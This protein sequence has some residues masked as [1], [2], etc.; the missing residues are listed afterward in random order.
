LTK[1]MA[2]ELAP[3]GVRINAICPC[4]VETPML[5]FQAATYG[6][7]DPDGYRKR[8][9]SIYPQ[10]D[11]A[12]FVRPEEVAE[13]VFQMASPK[14]APVTGAALSIDFGTTAGN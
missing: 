4:D 8:L 7:G 11:R 1:A 13:F 2:R 10:G 9:L 5:E 12:R 14:L 6:G 3:R